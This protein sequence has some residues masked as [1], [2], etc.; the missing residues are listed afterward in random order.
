MGLQI[1]KAKP[2][3]IQYFNEIAKHIIQYKI[4]AINTIYY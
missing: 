1:K 4:N 3:L 2:N